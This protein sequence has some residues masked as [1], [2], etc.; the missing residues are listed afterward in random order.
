MKREE[1]ERAILAKMEEIAEIYH[2]YNPNGVYLTMY[3]G[4]EDGKHLSVNNAG[5]QDGEDEDM[6]LSAWKTPEVEFY[7]YQYLKEVSA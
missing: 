2:Q 5:Y 3:I 1:C 4:G 7:Q 6:P